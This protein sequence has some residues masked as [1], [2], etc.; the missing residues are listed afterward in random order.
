MLLGWRLIVIWADKAQWNCSLCTLIC[1]FTNPVLSSLVRLYPAHI[2][3]QCVTATCISH[4][5]VL[6]IHCLTPLLINCNFFGFILG[7]TM[8][9]VPD[10]RL[11]CSQSRRL[12]GHH[13]LPWLTPANVIISLMLYC[14]LVRLL[15]LNTDLDV[16]SSVFK[17][18]RVLGWDE[19]KVD[20]GRGRRTPEENMIQINKHHYQQHARN[21]LE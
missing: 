8:V 4:T 15:T 12:E 14:T 11:P 2:T 18:P 10:C 20:G 21:A 6:Y 1:R 17:I 5:T 7:L 13:P 9:W 16:S 19:R 3:W